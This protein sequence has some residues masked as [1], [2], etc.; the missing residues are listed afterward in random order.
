MVANARVR[1]LRIESLWYDG[2]GYQIYW[3][4][5]Y[6][7]PLAEVWHSTLLKFAII[8]IQHFTNLLTKCYFLSLP[9]GFTIP[10]SKETVICKFSWLKLVRYQFESVLKLHGQ[11]SV[12]EPL[13]RFCLILHCFEFNHHRNKLLTDS[14]KSVRSCWG[15]LR[16]LTFIV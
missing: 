13:S 12:N 14:L 11:N 16:K 1:V 9:W 15:S 10:F 4:Y 8:K 6:L 5:K 2:S 7:F 3:A